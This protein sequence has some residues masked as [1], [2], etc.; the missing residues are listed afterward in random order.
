MIVKGDGT[1]MS[2]EMSIDRPID[3]ILSGPA[4]S[5]L[6]AKFLANTENALIVDMGGTTTDMALL[7]DGRVSINPQ[8]AQVGKWKTHVEAAKVRTTGS[9]RG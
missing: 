4:A 2:V 3:T 9:G 7:I 5:I 8:G 1:L 6:G